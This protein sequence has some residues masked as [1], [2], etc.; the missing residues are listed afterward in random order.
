MPPKSKRP[1]SQ[2][3]CPDL[4][5][6]RYCD[7]HKQLYSQKYNRDRGSAAKRGYDAEWRRARTAFLME[8][9]LCRHCLDL[10][11]LTAATVVDHIKPHKGDRGLF[12]DRKN[13]QPLCVSCHSAKTAKEDGGFGNQ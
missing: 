2:I 10:K 5:L 6:E 13:W 9:P 11:K 1:C 4:T 3:G 8:E 12:W 7:R